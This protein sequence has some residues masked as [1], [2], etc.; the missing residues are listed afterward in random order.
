MYRTGRVN[1]CA[2]KIKK[3]TLA[4]GS[5]VC[6]MSIYLS[7]ALDTI[8]NNSLITKLGAYGFQKDAILL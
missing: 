6:D 1:Q 3:I 5:F 7:K 8:N 2:S 4:K